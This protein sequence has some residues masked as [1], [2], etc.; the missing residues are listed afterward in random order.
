MKKQKEEYEKNN[1]KTTTK[2]L[3]YTFTRQSVH[4]PGCSCLC[5]HALT[6]FCRHILQI[7]RYLSR[8]QVCKATLHSV[9]KAAAA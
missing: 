9:A 3:G 5:M 7:V 2:N 8:E 6:A 4:P 1:N